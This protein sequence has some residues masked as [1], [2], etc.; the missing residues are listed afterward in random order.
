MSSQ[1]DKARQAQAERQGRFLIAIGIT[2]IVGIVAIGIYF[3]ADQESNRI[4]PETLCGSAPPLYVDL[5][6]DATDPY[7]PTQRRYLQ[8][9]IQRLIIDLPVSSR[10]AIHPV[11]D[12]TPRLPTLVRCKPE[13]GHNANPLYQNRAQIQQQW[14]HDFMV[15][16]EAQFTRLTEQEGA[17][18]SP[19]METIQAVAIESYQPLPL[20][21]PKRLI[22]ISDLLQHTEGWSHYNDPIALEALEQR[23]YYQRLRTDLRG[24]EVE[25]LMIRRAGF[26]Q[27]QQQ[28]L[29]MFWAEYVTNMGGKFISI[30]MVDG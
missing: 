16:V 13:D 21:R 23:P 18:Q 26:E 7:N 3:S 17:D 10:L 30:T 14:Q 4:D 22:I 29:A 1:F 5:I 6:I 28:R 11:R 24:A 12:Q 20:A 19:L 27:L 15:P 25:F 9:F 2:L 8:Q